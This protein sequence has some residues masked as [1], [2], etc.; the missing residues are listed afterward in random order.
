MKPTSSNPQSW[1]LSYHERCDKCLSRSSDLQQV[2]EDVANTIQDQ[3][4]LLVLGLGTEHAHIATSQAESSICPGP[5]PDFSIHL[6]SWAAS[7]HQPSVTSLVVLIEPISWVAGFFFLFS[8]NNFLTA[9][10]MDTEAFWLFWSQ[11]PLIFLPSLTPLSSLQVP[12]WL[13]MFHDWQ[14]LARLS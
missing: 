13:L 6:S 14:S 8:I 1:L 10:C 9:L 5:G 7:G 3:M 12:C 11:T 4:L 2:R